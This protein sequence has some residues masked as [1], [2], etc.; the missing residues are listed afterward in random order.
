M[1]RIHHHNLVDQSEWDVIIIGGGATGLGTALDSASR[2]L[3]TLLIEQSDFA[4]GT[5]SRSTKLVH[6][7]VRYLAQGDIALVKHALKERGLMQKNAAHLVHKEEFLIPCYNWFS[8]AKYL[9]GLKLYDWLAGRFSFGTSKYFSKSET[10]RL[11]PGIKDKGLKGSIRYF[12]GRFDDA[13]LAINIAQTAKEQG[14]TLINYMKVT[15]LIKDADQIKGVV[16][17]DTIT[18]ETFELKAKVVINATGVFVDE[19]LQ[20]NDSKARKTV[21]PSQGVHIVLKKEFLNSDS[22]LM[23]PQ[24]SDGRV[25]FAVQWHNHLLVGTTDT[26]LDEH[27]LEPR[28][29]KQ[30]TDFILNTAANYFKTKPTEKDILS[31]FSGLRPLAAPTDSNSNSTKEISRD[32]KLMVSAKGLITITGG[33]WTTYRRMAEETVNLAIK[34]AGLPFTACKTQQLAIHGCEIASDNN[35]MNIYGSD[36]KNIEALIKQNPELG[37]KLHPDFPYTHAEVV[38]SVKNEMVETVEDML[39]RRLRILIIDAKAAIAMSETVA[40][41][42]AKETGADKQWEAEQVESF[43][44][45]AEGYTYKTKTKKE[46]PVLAG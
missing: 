46:E 38:W 40:A 28:A 10:L 31:V 19:I 17:T 32:H 18:N 5:S 34:E 14:A 2:G 1:Q 44:K 8:V 7:G 24:T 12:D 39:S 13:R 23:I 42:I 27:S 35:Y 11:M 21:R 3:K 6:G 22:A 9:V 33:K 4:K 45:L 26:P 16:A 37:Q 15:S 20:M 41:I 30:E 36:R 29:L 25:L 43:V